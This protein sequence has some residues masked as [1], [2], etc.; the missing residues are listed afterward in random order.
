[1]QYLEGQTPKHHIQGRSMQTD[2][3][4]T[5]HSK[6]IVHRDIKP[7]NIFITQRGDAKVLDLDWLKFG[8]VTRDLEQVLSLDDCTRAFL[9]PCPLA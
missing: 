4:E 6:G 2:S 7:G 3:L 9:S 1:M 5:A 8:L